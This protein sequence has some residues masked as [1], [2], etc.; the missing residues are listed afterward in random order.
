MADPGVGSV[1]LQQLTEAAQG[2][3]TENKPLKAIAIYQRIKEITQN[4]ETDLILIKLY[5]KAGFLS[6]ARLLMAERMKACEEPGIDNDLLEKTCACQ[7]ELDPKHLTA[8]RTLGEIYVRTNR[9]K[10]LATCVHKINA[11]ADERIAAS[12][13]G[14]ALRCLQLL[15]DLDRL[16]T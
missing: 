6:E 5:R 12:D 4:P 13:Y 11:F 8:L 10:E 2:F 1:T 15:I 7:L 9:K 3:E 14:T 16:N